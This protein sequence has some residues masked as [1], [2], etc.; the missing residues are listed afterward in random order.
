MAK[1]ESEY[2]ELVVAELSVYSDLQVNWFQQQLA[3]LF[4]ESKSDLGFAQ[5]IR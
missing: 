2:L 4:Q 1:L 3:G 5:S